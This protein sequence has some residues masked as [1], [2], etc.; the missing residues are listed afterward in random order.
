MDAKDS[1]GMHVLNH[2]YIVPGETCL[3]AC[4]VGSS[5]GTNMLHVQCTAGFHSCLERPENACLHVEVS[6]RILSTSYGT[7]CPVMDRVLLGA[8]CIPS[9]R[10]LVPGMHAFPG[11]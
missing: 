8:L 1:P 5:L 7:E 9:L 3:E 2:E 4:N 6:P 11:G 10:A